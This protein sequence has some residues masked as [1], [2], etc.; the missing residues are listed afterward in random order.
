MWGNSRS[1]TTRW[2]HLQFTIW[3]CEY[4]FHSPQHNEAHGYQVKKHACTPH[5]LSLSK[6]KPTQSQCYDDDSNSQCRFPGVSLSWRRHRI[7]NG[8]TSH[9]Q[10]SWGMQLAQFTA[11]PHQNLTQHNQLQLLL[12]GWLCLQLYVFQ[13][14]SFKMSQMNV[15]LGL[16]DLFTLCLVLIPNNCTI[17]ISNGLFH[18]GKSHVS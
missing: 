9:Q 8:N 16:P 12:C 6:L 5:V 1:H 15:T 10:D 4:K 13:K 2:K 3:S 18:K 7:W 11:I 14:S 17:L